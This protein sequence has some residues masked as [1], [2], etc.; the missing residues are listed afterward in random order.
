MPL[1]PPRARSSRR[2]PFVVSS[3]AIAAAL[4]LAACSGGD[5]GTEPPPPPPSVS[6]VS[7]ALA[8]PSI[9]AGATTQATA[10]TRDASG[11][12][13]SGRSVAWSTSSSAVATVSGSGVVTGVA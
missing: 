8:S 7:V 1:M 10:T 6:T 12:V 2:A 9:V 13:L 5:G 11:A 3:V 4:G